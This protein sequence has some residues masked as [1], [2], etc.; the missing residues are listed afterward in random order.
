MKDLLG[1]IENVRR[2]EPKNGY[3]LDGSEIIQQKEVFSFRGTKGYFTYTDGV[4]I[5]EFAGELYYENENSK[6]IFN[7][8]TDEAFVEAWNFNKCFRIK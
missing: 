5:I 4:I 2:W 3:R 8:I 6:I 7:T 1:V